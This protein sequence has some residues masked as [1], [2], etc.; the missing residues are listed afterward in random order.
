MLAGGRC[1]KTPFGTFNVPNISPDKEHGIGNWSTLDFVTAM[2]LGIGPGGEHLYPA[3]PYTSYQRMRDE[4]LIDLKAYLD[5]L[6]ASSN[7]VPPHELTF[8]FNIRRALGLWQ[9]LYVDGKTF[10]PDPKAS[11]EVNRGAY[12]VQGPGHCSECHTSRNLLGGKVRV[13]RLCRRAQSRRQGHDPQHHAERRRHRRL[14]P[15]GHHLSAGDRQHARF[16]CH[17]RLDGRGAGEHGE[18]SARG[19]RGDRRLS[20]DAAA[21]AGCG[22]EIGAEIR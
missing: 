14:E 8:P 9:L 3:F 21:A 12:L 1:L 5:T 11:D 18:A 16:R 4:D 15:R 17:R 19:S 10:V 7:V 20:Q 13:A 2:K 22:A 6:P